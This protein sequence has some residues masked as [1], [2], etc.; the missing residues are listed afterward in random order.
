MKEEKLRAFKAVIIL[1]LI[2][3][4]FG[5][6]FIPG[7]SSE[8]LRV[9][10]WGYQLQEA[11][12]SEIASAGFDLM[13]I[14]YSHDGSDEGMYS[15]AEIRTI[16]SSGTIPIAYISIGE[17]EDYRFYWKAEWEHNPPAW[18][19]RTNP[20]WK[21]N[22]KVRYWNP[23]WQKIIYSYLDRIVS[24]GFLGV[25]LDIVDA[26]EYWSNPENGEPIHLTEKEAASRM[27]RFVKEI[28]EYC[29][30][31]L[32][33][34]DFYV[35]PQNGERILDYDVNNSFLNTISGIGIEDLFYDGL[36]PI[37]PEE[38]SYRIGYLERIH[39]VGKPVLVVD[40]VDN[41]TGYT[42]S[43]KARIDSF[44]AECHAHGYV[45]YAAFSDRELDEIDIIPEVQP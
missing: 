35:I 39:R 22:Y 30:V 43:N 16:R 3:T 32:G 36:D 10:N 18:L 17:A 41:G 6:L 12:P 4:V 7:E 13:V 45:P 11:S 44:I 25:Y 37:P 29:R 42:D 8:S 15:Q 34:P 5:C 27:I 26:F 23:E 20:D 24:Q 31:S 38:T 1:L 28:A 9:A 14:D 19:G 40:Y 21:G 33:K 2:S